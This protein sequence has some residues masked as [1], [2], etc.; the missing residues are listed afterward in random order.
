MPFPAFPH[1]R[2]PPPLVV[3]VAGREHAPSATLFLRLMELKQWYYKV[4]A[5]NILLIPGANDLPPLQQENVL[6]R[7]LLNDKSLG[8]KTLKNRENRSNYQLMGEVNITAKEAEMPRGEREVESLWASDLGNAVTG[9]YTG[10]DV[11][12]ALQGQIVSQD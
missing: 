10:H 1:G 4:P 11:Q 3:L 2:K 5:T 6:F 12:I 9:T 8:H 7:E